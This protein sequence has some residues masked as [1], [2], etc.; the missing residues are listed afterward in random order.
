LIAI[1]RCAARATRPNNDEDNDE[2]DDG[3]YDGGGIKF[4]M[5]Q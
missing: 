4:I 5:L 2:G 1:G 3:G